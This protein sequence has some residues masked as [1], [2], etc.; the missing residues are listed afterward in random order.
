MLE[1]RERAQGEDAGA[2]L[3][4]YATRCIGLVTGA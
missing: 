3:L 4:Q 1:S 2:Q